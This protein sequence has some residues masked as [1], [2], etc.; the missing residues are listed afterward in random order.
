[1]RKSFLYLLMSAMVL[2]SMG[3]LNSCK[4]YEDELRGEFR[5][6]QAIQDAT[7]RTLLQGC[8][9]TC[10]KHW[11]YLDSVQ[12]DCQQKC[13]LE[14]ARLQGLIDTLEDKLGG[15][16]DTADLNNKLARIW[17]T[18]TVHRTDISALYDSIRVH[19]NALTAL[20]QADVQLKAAIDTLKANVKDINETLEKH[21]ARITENK[22]SIKS[23]ITRVTIIES[24]L[25]DVI[26]RLKIAEDNINRLNDRI[27]RVY[28]TVSE[29]Q[30][31]IN[32]IQ[33]NVLDLTKLYANLETRLSKVEMNARE[34][35]ERAK[36]D[37]VWIK[38]LIIKEQKDSANTN[39]R[40]DTL[41][42]LSNKINTNLIQA[43]KN[44]D[45]AIQAL[46]QRDSLLADSL[47]NVVDE[48]VNVL[49]TKVDSLHKLN[50][51]AD[52]ILNDRIDSLAEVVTANKDSIDSIGKELTKLITRV[53]KVEQSQ[54][55][56]VTSI[57]LNAAYN[58]VFGTF[59]LPADVRNNVL[60][61]YYGV[62]E[63]SGKFPSKA[64]SGAYLDDS[65]ALTAADWALI[66][67][68]GEQYTYS[69]GEVVANCGDENADSID[70]GTLYLTVNP[71]KADFTGTEFELVNSLD[72]KAA[73]VLGDLQP[74]TRKMDFGYTRAK[75]TGV[76]KN[77]FYEAKVR[78]AKDDAESATIHTDG[79][80]DAVKQLMNKAKGASVS[81][82]KDGVH[83]SNSYV[84]NVSD[85][86]V[87]IL[88]NM[89]GITDAYAVRASWNDDLI[90]DTRSVYSQYGLAAVPVRSFTGYASFQDF[91]YK[92][93]PGYEA[94]W[95][96]VDKLGKAA[97]DA[98]ESMV[99][100]VD[101]I[102]KGV[103]IDNVDF[104]PPANTSDYTVD[105][106]IEVPA[107]TSVS[108]GDD[109]YLYIYDGTMPGNVLGAVPSNAKLKNGKLVFSFNSKEID[110]YKYMEPVFKAID[111]AY[112][113]VND[114]YED[115]RKLFKD[116][117]GLLNDIKTYEKKVDTGTGMVQ[118]LLKQ[119]NS[120]VVNLVNSA[121]Y[122]MQ[123]IMVANGQKGANILSQAKSVPSGIDASTELI[124]TNYVGEILAPALKKFVVCTNV[125]KDGVSA[126]DETGKVSDIQAC[127][128]EVK[129]INEAN[130]QM[131]VVLNGD[132]TR[133]NVKGFKS[134]YTYE[135][136]LSCLDY[137]G[138]Q[139]TRKFYVTV[140]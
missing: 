5:T 17:D 98:I 76:S 75:A 118:N 78:I 120:R 87:S 15:K 71:T 134:G 11:L 39:Y 114:T 29:I 126:Q 46:Q 30:N 107:G 133:I 56:L 73:A 113:D 102:I 111:E 57:E 8:Q 124:L 38:N 58:P 138:M 70:L 25:G 93:V 53:E 69:S 139:T 51:I 95:N 140:K 10:R 24:R 19:R 100:K 83:Y 94:A 36:N 91:N 108:E 59:N 103:D 105:M 31:T 106:T 119:L 67:F 116:V 110:L 2:I 42:L 66:N 37:S 85:V 14:H 136:A 121:N 40:I 41:S 55:A 81:I 132:V 74:S 1:M 68:T 130:D 112:D 64:G 7:L 3:T 45:A 117:S 104:T 90:G 27:D 63:K 88:D 44:Y 60:M 122:R 92:T 18:L 72:E 26:N 61:A 115:L 47:T 129:A 97:K 16:V 34:A 22:D 80:K 54:K 21:D 13:S 4:D 96:L 86:A 50:L 65:Y 9:D 48:K 77:G 52:S 109:G 131:N 33:Q 101:K 84:L 125:I 32:G 23:L 123:P 62:T 99:G 28:Y 79:I 43:M 82:D 128:N 49:D 6:D 12:K 127:Q 20:Q 137:Q 35:L 135:L 89:N